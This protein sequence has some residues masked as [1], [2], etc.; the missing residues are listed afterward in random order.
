MN[1]IQK[2]YFLE[3]IKKY[4]A[5]QASEAE[6]KFVEQF[7][8]LFESAEDWIATDKEEIFHKSTIKAHIDARI[9][10]DTEHKV[11]STPKQLKLKARIRRFAVAASILLALSAA[12][13]FTISRQ[14]SSQRL[15][16]AGK[17]LKPGGNTATLILADGSRVLLNEA[18]NGQISNQAGITVTKLKDGKLLYTVNAH[19]GTAAG[20]HDSAMYN[21]IETPKGGQY[22]VSLPDGTNVWLNAASS[23]RY[24]TVFS[25]HQREVHLDG[26]AYFE[27]AKN[28]GMPFIVKSSR[29]VVEVL[30]T[31]FNISSYH[32][33]PLVKTTLV[34]G[35]VRLSGLNSS[36][37]VTLN[38]GEQA[39]AHQHGAI[40]VNAVNANQFLGWK[41]G[42]FIF[43]DADIQSI[44]RQVSRWYNVEVIYKGGISK[45]KFGGSASRFTNVAELLEIL[46]LT[47]QVHFEIQ[48][49][50]ITVMP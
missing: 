17:H 41:E 40:T 49:R 14:G 1:S 42:K 21:T 37:T 48:G 30:G 32:D 39:L 16:A 8:G 50:R 43:T 36:Q 45:E 27:V 4:N 19:S 23:L 6:K 20:Q 11:S 46:E 47:H 29:Q 25:G 15:F 12:V 31:H 10:S 44:M 24:P 22:Q 3:I 9:A 5:G 38:A 18:A 2:Q 26:E 35:K 28:P 7:Y 13:Y 33:D 34:E